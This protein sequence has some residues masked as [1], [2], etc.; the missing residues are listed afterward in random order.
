MVGDRLDNDIAPARRLGMR[1]IRVLQG[2]GALSRP[3][4]EWE[5]PDGTVR[6]LAELPE[7][8]PAIKE[9]ETE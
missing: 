6:T 8:F 7:L 2:F 1:G 4:N 9:G 3:R 5:R